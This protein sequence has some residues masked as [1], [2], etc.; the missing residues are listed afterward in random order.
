LGEKKGRTPGLGRSEVEG[1]A[2]CRCRSAVPAEGRPV[3]GLACREKGEEDVHDVRG[4]RQYIYWAKI[5]LRRKLS[6]ERSRNRD[7]IHPF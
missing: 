5:A 3:E 1:Q 4:Q 2:R 6:R 7:D